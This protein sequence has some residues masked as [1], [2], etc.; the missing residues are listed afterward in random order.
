MEDQTTQITGTI[1]D[2]STTQP[3]KGAT[4]ETI[5]PIANE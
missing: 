5:K 1:I 2:Q 3:I 4:I